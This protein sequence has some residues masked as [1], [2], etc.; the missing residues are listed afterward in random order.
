MTFSTPPSVSI[1]L[2]VYNGEAFLS[3]AIESVLS[4][5]Y[6][7][8]ELIIS[9]NASTDGTQGI[10]ENFAKQDHR[11]KYSRLPENMGA[12]FN[13]NRVFQLSTGTYF[14]WAAHDDIIL[15][16]FVRKCIEVFEKPD[17][18]AP[19]PA[20]VYTD[21]VFIDEAGTVQ[22][23]DVHKMHS[24]S[25]F[26]VRRGTHAVAMMGMAAPVFGMMPR[27][28][29]E[30]TRLIDS[31]IASDYVL[32][33]EAALRGS[34]VRVDEP[35]FQ[36]RVHP[37]MSREANIKKKDV[38]A[39]FDP[40]ARQRLSTRQKLFVEYQRSTWNTQSLT[41]TQ[42]IFCSIGL[43]VAIPVRRLRVLQGRY[44]RKL[45]RALGVSALAN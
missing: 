35:L 31:F 45:A 30:T 27:R 41:V 9:D 17:E 10:C 4:Q 26:P 32:M 34:I 16:S 2:P 13:Y 39:W 8:L 42:K 43:C 15:P 21:S 12:A 22:G 18:S 23:R 14:K 11:V 33:Y 24:R 5:D 28:M 44:R 3:L 6:S 1:G 40:N 25:R 29:L 38:L 19:K 37:G 20:I 7:D 36:R